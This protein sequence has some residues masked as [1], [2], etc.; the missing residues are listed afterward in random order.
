MARSPWKKE[1]PLK[2]APDSTLALDIGGANIKAAHSRGAVASRPFA[3]WKTPGN[4]RDEIVDFCSSFPESGSVL[5][6]MTAELCDCFPTKRYG[7][8]HILDA[9]TSALP[10]RPTWIWGLNNRFNASE[11]IRKDP[12]RAAAANW[13]ALATVAARL[14]GRGDGLLI[15]IGSTTTDLIPLKNGLVAARG[16]TDTERLAT[17][18]L[19]YAGVRRTP[20]CAL[21]QRLPFRGRVIGLA[22]ELFASTLDVYLTWGAV[23]EEAG[24]TDTC[25]GRPATIEAARDRL[26]RMVG[27]DREGFSQEDA[28]QLAGSCH[29]ALIDRLTEVADAICVRTPGSPQTIILAGSGEFLGRELACR[30]GASEDQVVSLSARWGVDA[31]CAACA[32]S[33]LLLAKGQEREEDGD[34][35]RNQGGR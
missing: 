4:L 11:E 16:R 7:V 10:N 33:L 19:V 5:L 8:L 20:V 1:R 30:L 9:V 26:A 34:N 31:S 2:T 15:D 28:I 14:S 35:G 22:T 24:D 6:T 27:A 32:Y 23:P 21:A 12:L 18:E 13:L 17:G 25:D 29:E 3:V